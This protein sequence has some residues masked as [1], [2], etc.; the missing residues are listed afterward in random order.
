MRSITQI[1]KHFK[2]NWIEELSDDSIAKAC[3]DTGMTWL[4]SMLNPVVTIQIFLVQILHGNTAC[5]HMPRLCEM[6]F[7]AAGY[8]K[9]RMR[10]K[11]EV[12]EL[13]LSRCVD[14]I[15]KEAF[16]TGR[17]F[18]HRVFMVDGSSFSMPDTIPLQNHFGRTHFSETRLRISDSSLVGNVAHGNPIKGFPR[19]RWLRR[20]GIEDQVVAWLKNH[21]NRPAWMTR[22]QFESLPNEITVR[23]LRY[24]INQ[25]GFRAKQITLVTTLLDHSIYSLEELA[26]LFRKR[27]EIETH[28]GHIKTTMAMD[29]LKCKT[30]AGVLKELHVFAL[31]YNLVRQVIVLA[32]EEQNVAVERIS[33][34][35]A[36]RWLQS[37]RSSDRLDTLFVNPLRPN[38]FEPRV[39]KRRPKTY[40]FMT[41]PRWQLKKELATQ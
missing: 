18:G 2:Q 11:L 25:K 15:Q 31:L 12:F 26:D 3:R 19:S 36:L 28:F 10:I 16:D 33:F 30:V 39:R 20:L 32:A 14:S 40:T 9:A 1:V 29:V 4:D 23:E 41:K 22:E 6:A 24:T 35:D 34:I 38:R 8:C 7:T 5:Q 37:A 17:W 13:L 27:W 21:S